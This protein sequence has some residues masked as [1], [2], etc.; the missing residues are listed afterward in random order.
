MPGAGVSGRYWRL[1][2]VT[3]AVISLPERAISHSVQGR[4][5][6]PF[7]TVAVFSHSSESVGVG[8]PYQR[9]RS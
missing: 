4:H 6:E 1:P 5:H 9:S 8:G 7:S 3:R 2:R